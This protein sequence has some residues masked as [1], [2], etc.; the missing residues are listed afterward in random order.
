VSES[1][2]DGPAASGPTTRQKVSES[3]IDNLGAWALVAAGIAFLYMVWATVRI[4][5]QYVGGIPGVGP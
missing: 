1:T 4:L 3:I 2:H 5:T